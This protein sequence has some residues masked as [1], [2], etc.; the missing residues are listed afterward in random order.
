MK[1]L[2]LPS[3]FSFALA[4][5]LAAALNAC[6]TR[7]DIER[8][9]LLASLAVQMRDGQKLQS[10]AASR[11][12]ALEERLGHVSGQ[13]E[14]GDHQIA[15]KAEGQIQSLQE[16]VALLESTSAGIQKKLSALEK[17]SRSQERYL[18]DVLRTLQSLSPGTATS[19]RSGT[20]SLYQ[21]AVANYKAGKY[22]T[23][24]QQFA[25]LIKSKYLKYAQ[26]TRT[27]HNL[28]MIAYS[29]KDNDEAIVHFGR[30][31]T[32]Y[33]KSSYNKRGLLF[34]AKAFMRLEES[35]KAK[36]TLQEL[37]E[38]HPKSPQA[39]E[40]KKLLKKL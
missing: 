25:S 9:Q 21:R 35:V 33:P 14:E 27:L 39:R 4:L 8:E 22:K 36:Q 18:K 20:N 26:K 23:A 15:Q 1:R 32:R 13:V 24:K 3:P 2:C 29:N 6:K 38:R 37:T 12:Q 19:S 17:K 7:G 5:A 31:F 11:I 16:K 40:A 30:L 34:M 28:G 10:S